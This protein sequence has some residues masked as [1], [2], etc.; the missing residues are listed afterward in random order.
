MKQE[1]LILFESA[2]TPLTANEIYERLKTKNITLSSIYRTLEKFTVENILIKNIDPKGTAIY[3]LKQEKHSH[4]LECKNCHSKVELG[5]CPYHKI[6]DHINNEFN[7]EVDEQ[8]VVIY[9]TC[10]DCNKK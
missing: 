4:Y 3:T 6:N 10:K 9:G 5:Y 2:N 8:N 7:F 1:V